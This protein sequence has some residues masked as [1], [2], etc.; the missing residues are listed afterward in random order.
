LFMGDSAVVSD[1]PK[2][3]EDQVA[4]GGLVIFAIWVFFVLPL[5]FG[6]PTA[7]FWSAKLTDWLLAAFSLALAIFT[8]LLYRATAGMWGATQELRNFAEE[9]SRDMKASIAVANAAARAAQKSADVA[10]RALI[11]TERA[12]VFL[13]YAYASPVLEF[14]PAMQADRIIG[15]DF[16]VVWANAG[17]TPTQN[18]VTYKNLL[19]FKGAIPE[20]FEFPDVVLGE[21]ERRTPKTFIGPKAEKDAG[22][23]TVPISVV[24]N[25]TARVQRLYMWGWAEYSDV[26]RPDHRSRSEYC[27]E[28]LVTGDP[29]RIPNSQLKPP[30][31]FVAFD[32]H[33][34]SEGE[35]YRRPGEPTP[36]LHLRS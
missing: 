26:F 4:F 17:S 21:G 11:S 27:F 1:L 6:T 28:I 15:W 31:D 9:Q 2:L 12:F 16:H 3:S 34:G 25:C 22:K 30:F 24:A 29:H 35:C 8:W 7:E 13:K 10:E 32:K 19:D 36:I 14:S 5:L 33:N 18:M 20:D 23:F